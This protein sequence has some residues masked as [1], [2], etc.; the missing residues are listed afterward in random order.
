MSLYSDIELQFKTALRSQDKTALG[1]LRLLRTAIKNR[2]VENRGELDDEQMLQVIRTQVKRTK[3]AAEAYISAGEA[4]RA[5]V[6]EEQQAVLEQ[7]LPAMMDESEVRAIVD[8]VIDEVGAVSH[9]DMGKVMKA[10][11]AEIAGRADGKKVSE[12]VKSKLTE[13]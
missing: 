2:E 10:V 12:L 1:V 3:E 6:E 13:G 11:M 4:E 8:R 5:G 7:F 9:K